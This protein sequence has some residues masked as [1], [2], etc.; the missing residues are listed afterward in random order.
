MFERSTILCVK[1]TS[2]SDFV[3]G[4]CVSSSPNCKWWSCLIRHCSQS[5][6]SSLGTLTPTA[7]DL[8]PSAPCYLCMCVCVCVAV[9]TIK[10]HW[11]PEFQLNID[12]FFWSIQMSISSLS[13]FIIKSVEGTFPQSTLWPSNRIVGKAMCSYPLCFE[14]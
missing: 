2:P 7:S 4:L 13:S 14:P 10:G 1:L 5:V 3:C 12:L 6:K 8:A 11:L 9:T